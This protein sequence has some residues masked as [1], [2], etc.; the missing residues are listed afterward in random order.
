MLVLLVSTVCVLL[1]C[2]GVAVA[3]ERG[4]V[5]TGSFGESGGGDGQF[6]EPWDVAV[7]EALDDIYV[8]DHANDRVE[9]FHEGSGGTV[10]YVGQFNGSGTFPG[11]GIRA[12]SGSEHENVYSEVETGQFDEPTQ[13]AVD[14]SCAYHKL[15]GAACEKYDPSNGDVYLLDRGHLVI[16]KYTAAGVYI[17]Q[18][19]ASTNGGRYELQLKGVGVSPNGTVYVGALAHGEPIGRRVYLYSNSLHNVMCSACEPDEFIPGNLQSDFLG[20]GLAVN[21]QGDTY[22]QQ[23]SL[24]A[25]ALVG[26]YSSSGETLALIDRVP[27]GLAVE[28]SDSDLYL[29]SEEG[30]YRYGPTGVLL[31]QFG[32]AGLVGSGVAVD[33]VTGDVFVADRTMGVV[34]VFELEPAGPATIK[35]SR[36]LEVEASTARFGGQI[37]PR[38]A[39]TTYLVEYGPCESGGCAGSPYPKY[40]PIVSEESAGERYEPAEVDLSVSGLA[41]GTEYHFRIVATNHV[42]GETH[43]STGEELV[44]TTRRAGTVGLLD[45][46]V[47]EQVS[48]EAKGGALFSPI[49]EQSVTQAAG[50]GDAITFVSSNP[51]EVD[52]AGFANAVQVLAKRDVGGGWDS[53]DIATSHVS[54]PGKSIGVGAEYRFFSGDLSVGLVQPLGEFVGL[55]AGASQQTPYVRTDFGSGEHGFCAKDCYRPVVTGCPAAGKHCEGA[56]EEVADVPPGT[57]FSVTGEACV[58]AKVCGPEAL[59]ASPD[60]SAVV[61]ASNYKLSE[62]SPA[63]MYEWVAGRLYYAGSLVPHGS[64][65][66]VSVNDGGS[67]LVAGQVRGGEPLRV[68]DPLSGEEVEVDGGSGCGGCESG[69]GEDPVVAGEGSHVFFRDKR[70]LTGASDKG[71]GADDLYVCEVPTA[72][73]ACG[74]TDLTPKPAVGHAD[75]LGVVAVSED[76]SSVYF[77]ANGDLAVGAV[78]GTCNEGATN[79]EG[80]CNLYVARD[81]GSGWGAP[82]LVGVVSGADK[83][84]WRATYL[85]EHTARAAGEWLVFMSDRSLTGYDNRDVVSGLPDEEVFSYDEAGSGR[86]VCVSCNPTGERPDGVEYEHLGKLASG[87]EI[88]PEHQGIAANVPGYTPF[89][90]ERAGYDSRFVGSD[91][92]VF[93][94]SVVGLVAGDVNGVGDVYEWEPVGVGSCSEVSVSFSGRTGGCLG[95]VS[96][97]RAG[98]EAGFLDASVSGGDV[99]FLTSGQLV[100]GDV[101]HSVDVYDAHECTVVAPC[102]GEVAGPVVECA[103]TESCHPYTPA[104]TGSGGVASEV[105]SGSGNFLSSPLVVKPVVLSRA[106]KLA[107]AL[108]ACG[109]DKSRSK[110]RACEARAHRSYGAVARKSAARKATARKGASD[111]VRAGR[112]G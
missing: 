77:V 45:G 57:V 86:L 101:D 84:D 71:T 67:R 6:A 81:S 79:T 12:G 13:I 70:A 19:T 61:L 11:E 3:E 16:D 26:E 41:P 32:R 10:E 38:G 112:G 5:Y 34:D 50:S 85:P 76:G 65:G 92:R 59:A 25:P 35:D 24:F 75:V 110:R 31:E 15:S 64:E 90:L 96:S 49:A 39:A 98:E 28:V 52:P 58:I 95:L 8:V 99:F 66:F 9:I 43:I 62:G 21:G 83:P 56:V 33:D 74:L 51:T 69:G 106:Q 17:G 105:F 68:V 104:S 42:G 109:K 37:N 107:K 4:H 100:S 88:W 44:F 60:V 63:G 27:W 20:E 97:G 78:T 111:G 91:G 30:V 89:A 55:S 23:Y 7:N 54:P 46:R 48:P 80:E 29:G 82:R 1:G 102:G 72:K 108:R 47:W 22:V 14:N 2:V 18:I 36:V 103:S 53:L 87:V 93:F 94:D 73:V 40:V